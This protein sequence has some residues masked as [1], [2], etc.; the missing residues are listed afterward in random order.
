MSEKKFPTQCI[1]WSDDLERAVRDVNGFPLGIHWREDL[2][3]RV[4]TVR[5]TGDAKVLS[6][7]Y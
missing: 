5:R 6:G 2:W 1:P 4:R 3:Q 7:W